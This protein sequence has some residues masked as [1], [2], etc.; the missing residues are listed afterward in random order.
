MKA[1]W[2]QWKISLSL[3]AIFLC[4]QGIG[5][6]LASVRKNHGDQTKTPAT[7]VNK[8]EDWKARSLA[9]L[10]KELNLTADQVSAA[11]AV[12]DQTRERIEFEK[13]RANFNAFLQVYRAHADLKPLLN[14]EQAAKLDKMQLELDSQ[15]RRQFS[16]ILDG[17]AVLDLAP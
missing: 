1:L 15:I 10:R 2:K 17:P 14:S 12:L 9:K 13:E 4:G 8:T 16:R 6:T 5:Y 3:L 7:S 11:A